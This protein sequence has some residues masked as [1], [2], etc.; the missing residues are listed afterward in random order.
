VNPL[1]QYEEEDRPF[2]FKP[3][4]SHRKEKGSYDPY[5]KVVVSSKFNTEARRI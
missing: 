5:F 1:R 4:Y 3:V 2:A